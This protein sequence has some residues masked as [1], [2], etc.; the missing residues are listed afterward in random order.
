MALHWDL[1]ACADYEALTTEE[2]YPLT[3]AMVFATMGTGIGTITEANWPEFYARVHVAG[4]F[5]VTPEQVRRYI[6]LKTNVF[7]V[8][9]RAKWLKRV[10][11]SRVD[12]AVYRAKRV[13]SESSWSEALGVDA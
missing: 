2:N 5:D 4:Y 7:P 3:E 9:S 8:E 12:D 6:G 10:M 11:G 1:T 13:A